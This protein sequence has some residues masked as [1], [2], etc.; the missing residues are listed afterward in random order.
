MC[1]SET[2]EISH[3]R[4]RHRSRTPAESAAFDFERFRNEILASI[5]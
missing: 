2:R 1:K 3:S 5:E 4:S